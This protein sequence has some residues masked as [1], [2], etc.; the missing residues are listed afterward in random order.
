MWCHR[1]VIRSKMATWQPFWMFKNHVLLSS[2]KTTHVGLLVQNT[3]LGHFLALFHLVSSNS[4]SDPRW[5]RGGSFE[6]FKITFCSL[7]RKLY[8]CRAFGSKYIIRTLFS[9]LLSGMI[10]FVIGSKMAAWWPF[11][12]FKNHVLFSSSK[13]MHVGLLVQNTLLAH[14]LALFHLVSSI[15]WSDPRWPPGSHFECLKI[16]FCSLARKLC[17]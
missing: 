15:L 16:T 10:D 14:F 13:T 17:M 9:T 12:V 7:P 8:M 1:Y 5:L 6:C 4:W 3:L 11:W 2:L